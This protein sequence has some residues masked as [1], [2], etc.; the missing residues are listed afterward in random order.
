[1]KKKK[2]T[3]PQAVQP[4]ALTKASVSTGTS[5]LRGKY[6]GWFIA[7]FAVV[8][9]I[10]SVTFGYVLDDQATLHGNRFV[11]QGLEGIPTLIKWNTA[12]LSGKISQ[13]VA[14]KT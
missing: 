10:Q 7:A 6:L 8:L 14:N 13:I 2:P 1:M 4:D 11:T 5:V 12:G 9:Y 3:K